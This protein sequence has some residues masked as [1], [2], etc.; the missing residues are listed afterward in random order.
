VEDAVPVPDATPTGLRPGT[1]GIAAVELGGILPVIVL[2]DGAAVDVSDVYPSTRAMFEDWDAAF[3]ALR[4]LAA[5]RTPNLRFADLRV[6]PPV[7]RPDLLCAGSNY[8][9]HVAQMLTKNTFN[10]HN[11]RPGETDEEFFQR[12]YEQTAARRESG[13]PFLWTGMHSS[14]VGANDDIVLP[15]LGDQPDWELELGVVVSR[16]SRYSSLDEAQRS[17]AGYVMINDLGTVDVFRRTDIHFGFDWISKNQPTFK[18]IGPFVVPA[19]FVDV[20]ELRIRLS[21]NGEVMQD[22]PADDFNFGPAELVAYASER[23]RLLPGDVIAMGS[24]PGNGAHN[25]GRFLRDGDIV[26]SEITGLGR[27]RNRCV[28]EDLH[29]RTPVFGHWTNAPDSPAAEAAR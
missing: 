16:V 24:P 29:G 25:G 5:R 2:P 17:I 12:N 10:Q 26:E 22:W 4:D 20:S 8:V 11:R 19:P 27:Q 21:V 7:E 9:T 23:V 13:T 28:S 1:F 14:L 3:P 15:E 18:P 6:L